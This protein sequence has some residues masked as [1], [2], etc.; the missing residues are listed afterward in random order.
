[1]PGSYQNV[2]LGQLWELSGI[3][4]QLRF[5]QVQGLCRHWK[6]WSEAGAEQLVAFKGPWQNLQ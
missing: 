4:A 5:Q 3:G 1:M 6:S 2:L